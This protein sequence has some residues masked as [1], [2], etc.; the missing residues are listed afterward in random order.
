M[1]RLWGG[2]SY[3]V[4]VDRDAEEKEMLMM[5]IYSAFGNIDGYESRH[6]AGTAGEDYEGV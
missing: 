3:L 2:I 5:M 6:E 1:G 4:S